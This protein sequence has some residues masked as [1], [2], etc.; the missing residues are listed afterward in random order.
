MKKFLRLLLIVF[1]VSLISS[2][3]VIASETIEGRSAEKWNEEGE[4]L[5]DQFLEVYGTI[6]MLGGD[7]TPISK[8]EE[9]DRQFE[10]MMKCF[11]NAITLDPQNGKYYYNRAIG[12]SLNGDKK[13][14]LIDLKKSCDL[15]YKDGCKEYEYMK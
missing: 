8:S 4:R 15:G 10:Y 6:V 1:C 5:L 3:F 13:N 9:G 11:N 2:S 12:Y 14:A 7:P